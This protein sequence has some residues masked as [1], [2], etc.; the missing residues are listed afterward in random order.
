MC[1]QNVKND[2]VYGLVLA[3]GRSKRMRK[4]KALIAYHGESQVEYCFHL[5]SQF[6]HEVFI[7]NRKDQSQLK[8]HREFPQVNDTFLDIGPLGGILSAM[9]AYPS[10]AWIVLAC[11]LPFVNSETIRCLL[12]NRHR[13]KIATVYRSSTNPDL[14]EPLCAIYEAQAKDQLLKYHNQGVHCP[15]KIFMNSNIH[16]VEQ[17]QKFMLENINNPEEYDKT[18]KQIRSALTNSNTKSVCLTYYAFLRDERGVGEE[19]VETQ[20]ETASDL[21]KELQQ[22]YNFRMPGE[23]LKVAINDSI[24]SWQTKLRNGDHVVLIPPVSGG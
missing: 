5:L 3:G 9:T 14:P 23:L 19:I 17:G 15:R 10:V 16:F 20:A 4:D 13:L 2:I 11:D 18:M 1:Q 21:Y 12:A 6:C 7:S 8:G 24:V 22:K